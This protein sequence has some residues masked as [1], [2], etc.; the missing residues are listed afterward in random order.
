M[1]FPRHS[2]PVA[3]ALNAANSAKVKIVYF[4]WFPLWLKIYNDRDRDHDPD[5]KPEHDH[6]P[7]HDNDCA[8]DR[9][10]ADNC[11]PDRERDNEPEPDPDRGQEPERAPEPAHDRDRD[12]EPDHDHDNNRYCNF[13]ELIILRFQKIQSSP[14]A[15]TNH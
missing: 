12:Q 4:I 15:Q 2:L 8:P 5:P 13:L 3:F 11:A 1:Q 9:D 14:F 6:E 7:E 10:P